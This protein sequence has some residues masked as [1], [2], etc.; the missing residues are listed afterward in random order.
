MVLL[1]STTTTMTAVMSCNLRTV[2]YDAHTRE[3]LEY[4]ETSS[5]SGMRASRPRPY[6]LGSN[7]R[8]HALIYITIY[9]SLLSSH[10]RLYIHIR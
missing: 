9:V 5:T 10:L 6:L 3:K 7:E 4:L 8:C 2:R 1:E